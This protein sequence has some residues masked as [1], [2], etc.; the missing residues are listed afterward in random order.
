MNETQ[1]GRGVS[2]ARRASLDLT[3]ASRRSNTESKIVARLVELIE[4]ERDPEKSSI[5]SVVTE[6]GVSRATYFRHREK[7]TW[8][9]LIRDLLAARAPAAAARLERIR[10]VSPDELTLDPVF[11]PGGTREADARDLR[12]ILDWLADFSRRE[13]WRFLTAGFIHPPDPVSDPHGAM[14]LV[15][16]Y[17]FTALR[18]MWIEAEGADESGDEGGGAS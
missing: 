6:A 4:Q 14:Q 7:W 15:D 16:F 8:D 13:P 18:L 17:W 5:V 1:D 10:G 11:L 2:A 3:A 12:F 9:Y